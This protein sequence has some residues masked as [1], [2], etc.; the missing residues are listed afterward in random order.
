MNQKIKTSKAGFWRI[1][2]IV[3]VIAILFVIVIVSQLRMQITDEDSI[4]HYQKVDGYI[5]LPENSPLRDRIGVTEV[6]TQIIQREVTAPA[7]VEAK[8]SMR[9]NIFPPAGGRIVQL[10]VNMG[11]NVRTGVALFE[12]YSPEVAEV[13][14]EYINARSALVQ[15]ERAFKR[16]DDLH[17]KGIAPLRELEEANTA[18]EIAKSEMEGA[19]LKL[20]IL[21]IDEN[22]L[23]KPL[24]VC[25]PINGRVVDLRVAPGEFITEPEEPLMIIA[26]LSKIWVIANIQE[27]DI[28]FVKPN[29]EVKAS[30]AAYPGEA[31]EGRVLFVGDILDE[32][33]RTTR[34][35]VE[36]D[37]ESLKLKPGMFATV[38]LFSEPAPHIVIDPKAVLQRRDYNYVYVQ[39]DAFK[40]EKRKVV[41][42]E[43][44]EGK[45]VILEGLSEGE[46]IVGQNAVTLP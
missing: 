39:K 24:I 31:Y 36:F 42:G 46:L 8:P 21:G 17:E 12:I 15:A 13:Q 5:L 29:A 32:D 11:Q 6:E 33:T 27:K 38:N 23:G 19:L 28:R 18:Y 20:R 45:I 30:F 34:V 1:L 44:F 43:L 9:A 2:A 35:V 41:T 4:A 10:F 26:D 22:N 40:F 16:K 37:N 14:T 25:S 3:S 7:T